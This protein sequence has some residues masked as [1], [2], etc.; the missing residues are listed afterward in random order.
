MDCTRLG[1]FLMCFSSGYK[2]VLCLLRRLC[3]LNDKINAPIAGFIAALSLAIDSASR[4]QLIAI[5]MFSRAIDTSMSL[6]DAKGVLPQFRGRNLLIWILSNCSMQA[7]MAFRSSV[8]N[9][10]LH[11]FFTKY[12]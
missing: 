3:T 7:A 8:L 9:K 4:R 12:S 1:L 11:K 10:G 6:G 5:L 2:T